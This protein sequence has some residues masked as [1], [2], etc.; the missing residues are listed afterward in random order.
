MD[1]FL[2]ENNWKRIPGKVNTADLMK[3]HSRSF[4]VLKFGLITIVR[5]VLMICLAFVGGGSIFGLLFILL[6]VAIM[7][8]FGDVK[9]Y[10][11]PYLVEINGE[12]SRREQRIAHGVGN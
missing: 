10:V 3:K 1:A 5:V 4:N 11:Y 9:P 12:A 8:S 6:P 2:K 7:V